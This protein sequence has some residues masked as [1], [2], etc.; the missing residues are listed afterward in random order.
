MRAVNIVDMAQDKIM[1]AFLLSPV[2]SGERKVVKAEK[3]KL[4]G[5]ALIL[6]CPDERADAIIEI[7]RKVYHKNKFRFYESKTGVGWKRI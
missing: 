1:A 5:A 6:D 4:D 2:F 3:G 7:V